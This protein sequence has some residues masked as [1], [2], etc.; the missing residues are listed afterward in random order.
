MSH[1]T[2]IYGRIFIED[3]NLAR[4]SIKNFPN[5]SIIE[6]Q[7]VSNQN[8]QTDLEKVEQLYRNALIEKQK[9]LEEERRRLEEEKKRLEELRKQLEEEKRIVKNQQDILRQLAVLEERNLQQKEAEENFQ[10]EIQKDEADKKKIR[11]QK[12]AY[13]KE[14]E[15]KII[16]N[17][18]KKGYTVKKRIQENG[19]VKLILTLRVP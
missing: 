3:L 17:A 5:V 15:E 2:T 12:L 14:R 1:Y 4:E 7:F 9:R 18:A 8:I 19:K 6:Y 16:Q 13:Q 10:K 11:E